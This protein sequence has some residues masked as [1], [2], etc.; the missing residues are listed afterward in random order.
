LNG[1]YF[2]NCCR[3]GEKDSEKEKDIFMFKFGKKSVGLF[4]L[5]IER[6]DGVEK[7]SPTRLSF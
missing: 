4:D 3:S 7:V 5:K 1:V 6:H 2:Y